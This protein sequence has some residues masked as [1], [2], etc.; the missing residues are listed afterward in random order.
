MSCLIEKISKCCENTVLF[1]VDNTQCLT[2][3]CNRYLLNNQHPGEALICQI[4]LKRK[5]V[6]EQGW[7]I[8]I[9]YLTHASSVHISHLPIC[10]PKC[11]H[12]INIFYAFHSNDKLFSNCS[13]RFSMR[14]TCL[15]LPT[16][17]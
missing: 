7:W 16:H 2:V 1:T 3:Q 4:Q 10:F 9:L 8:L 15:P 6:R 17:Q 14:K 11:D 13:N 12:N 5:M